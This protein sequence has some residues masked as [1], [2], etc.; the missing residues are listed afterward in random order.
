MTDT[1][2]VGG[3]PL[4]QALLRAAADVPGSAPEE[5]GPAAY[6]R[7]GILP[8]D[9]KRQMSSV[10]VARQGRP[11]MLITK[12]APEAVFAR[13]Q[14]LPEGAQT[15]LGKL[16]ADGDRV[17]AVATRDLPA[18]TSAITTQDERQLTLVGFL[19]FADRPKADAGPAVAQLSKLGVDVKIITGDNGVVAAKVCR[20]IGIDVAGVMNGTDLVKLDDQGLA[21]AI[22]ETT[23]FARVSPEQKSRII[24]VARGTGQDVA[25]M[26]DGVNDAVA[27][28]HADVGISVDSG[29]DVA[30]DAA[31]VVLLEKDLGV[32]ATGVMEGRRIFGNTMKY[33]LMATSSNFGNM[34]SAAGASLFLKFLP[35]L[36]SQ[37]LL[38]NL[39]YDTGQLAIPTDNVD[40]ETLTRPAAWDIRFVRRFM[41][42]F[43]PLS[44]I[45]DFI[46][47]GVLLWLLH[48]GPSEF[49]TG[50]FVESIAT[51]TLIIYVIRTRRV[52]FFR[53]RPSR[54]MMFV[55]TAA[56]A[57]GIIL[58]FTALSHVLG[59]T[60]LPADFFLILVGLIVAYLVL[61]DVAKSLFYRA[62]RAQPAPGAQPSRH[63]ARPVADHQRS[64]RRLH[65]R[66]A[67][68]TVHTLAGPGRWLLHRDSSS[69]TPTR[70]AGRA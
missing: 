40:P 2:P 30:K 66:A 3:N 47:F 63:G 69:G 36:P 4:D 6:R 64:V 21:A 55:P 9:H 56:A 19:T 17:V 8:F 7:L 59:F 57:V 53:S 48:A 20:E 51:Q 12:G 26:G 41:Y 65:R 61:V 34:F 35:M 43:G 29:T 24:T 60:P 31:D 38:N 58:P 62:Q 11:P 23:V 45:F 46:T 1:G 68:F 13:C 15:T 25:F 37:I 42:T 33:V 18:G 39:L 70:A 10:L 49:R 16:F 67:P 27:I 28:H 50:W 22:P 5:G 52:P 14:V 44:S 54:P 32:L